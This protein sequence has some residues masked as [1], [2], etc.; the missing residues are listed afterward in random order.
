VIGT[1]HRAWRAFIDGEAP[2]TPS[3]LTG[4]VVGVVALELNAGHVDVEIAAALGS[5]VTFLFGVLLAFSIART[6]ERLATVQDLITT[7]N[8]ALLSI[9]QLASVFGDPTHGRIRTLIDRQLTDQID[10][11][12]VDNHL[13]APAHLALTATL[14]DLV[15][16]TRQEEVAYKKLTELCV[17][18]GSNRALIEATT[19][20]SLSGI[21]WTGNFLLLGVLLVLLV[22]LPNGTP[23]GAVAAGFLAGTLVALLVLLRRLDGLRWHERVAIWEPTTRLFRN[24][25]L[26]PYVPRVVIDAGRYRPH[27]RVRVVDYPDP[28]PVRSTKVVTVMDFDGTGRA[29]T[30]R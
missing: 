11:R 18:M 16:Q 10:Y 8:A 30:P 9:D 20:Q 29:T 23:W 27:G 13:S 1:L 6:R 5:M 2:L 14:F 7:G 12:L 21:E 3:I 25:D 4:V 24:M 17:D 28:Y 26:D 22:V 19:G 15:P